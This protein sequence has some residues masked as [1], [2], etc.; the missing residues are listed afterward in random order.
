MLLNLQLGCMV[1]QPIQDVCGV[2]HASANHLGVKRCVAVR[3]VR[4]ELNAGTRAAAGVDLGAAFAPSANG[5]TLAVGRGC[6]A[7]ASLGAEFLLVLGID[8]F[9]QR[10]RVGFISDVPVR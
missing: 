6:R 3:D 10:Q 5:K 9:G 8:D 2:S 4:V 7:F 1:K